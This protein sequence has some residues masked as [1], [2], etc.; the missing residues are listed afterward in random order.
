MVQEWQLEVPNGYMQLVFV[1]VNTDHCD[2]SCSGTCSCACSDWVEVSYGNY[3]EKFCSKDYQSV[4]TNGNNDYFIPTFTST[5][6]MTVRMHTDGVGGSKGFRAFWMDTSPDFLWEGDNSVV[7]GS[8][9]A[10]GFPVS[11]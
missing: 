10:H 3:S 1:S 6:Q 2:L 11:G 5:E 8:N 9:W 7:D 4:T